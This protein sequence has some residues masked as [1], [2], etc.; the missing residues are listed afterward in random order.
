MSQAI[1][2]PE[3]QFAGPYAGEL[4][5]G[6]EDHDVYDSGPVLDGSEVACED[7]DQLPGPSSSSSV[8]PV[9]G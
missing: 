2:D 1:V 3:D 8:A 7:P 6:L 5:T 9:A 4:G